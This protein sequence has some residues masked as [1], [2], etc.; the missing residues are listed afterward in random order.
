MS[1][2]QSR[3]FGLKPDTFD[4]RDRALYQ[5]I[6]DINALPE[7]AS[8][9]NLLP[10]AMDQDVTSACTG[11]SGATVLYGVMVKDKHRRPFVPS[12]VFL[13]R[14][15][16]VL[17]GYLDED[18]GAEIRNVWKAANKLGIPPM[19]NLKPRFDKASLAQPPDYIFPEKS[20]W[21]RQPSPSTYKDA[22]TR[23]AI[24]YF[25]LAT[26]ADLL[27]CLA[28]GWPAQVGITVFESFYGPNGPVFHVPDKRP[29][30]RELGG[31][32]I[33]AY[34]YDRTTRRVLFR[35]SWGPN[36]HEGK[37]DFSLS[38]DYLAAYGGDCWTGRLIEGGLPV[39]V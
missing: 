18:M 7:R 19:S 15:A 5:V 6:P 2:F 24:Q 20:I 11:F 10:P 4:R 3:G 31:H 14:E 37:P 21:R 39:G 9:A 36:A 27:K 17:G 38:F 8:V 34:A 23:Q 25:R 28:D 12:P 22:L 30:D 1:D 35:N 26:L 33:A 29:N 16:R 13:Y 32:A